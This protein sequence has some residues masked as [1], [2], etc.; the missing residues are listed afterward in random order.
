MFGTRYITLRERLSPEEYLELLSAHP[1]SIKKI[2]IVPPSLSG[3]HLG[4]IEVEFKYPINNYDK[5]HARPNE[6]QYAGTKD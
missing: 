3:A 1:S 2:R 4:E 6:W 5:V